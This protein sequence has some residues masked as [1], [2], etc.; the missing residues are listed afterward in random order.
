MIFL[1][2]D[3]VDQALPMAELIPA[4]KGAYTAL[5]KGEVELPLRIQIPV[6]EEEGV[7]LFMPAYLH[8]EDQKVITL[9]T[10]NVF[11]RNLL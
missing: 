1:N 6:T 7:A 2:A 9:K 10:V 3:E 8:Q 11:P 4:V 5:T